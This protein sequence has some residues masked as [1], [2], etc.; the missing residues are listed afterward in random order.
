MVG[1]AWTQADIDALDAANSGNRK[2]VTMSD[3]RSVT[4]GS[5]DDYIRL[6]KMMLAE[7]LGPTAKPSSYS[8]G[9]LRR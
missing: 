2:S 1:M 8:V 5:V 9:R 7:V 6:R 3:G 4:W